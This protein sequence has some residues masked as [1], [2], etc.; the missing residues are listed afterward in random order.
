[1]TRSYL[2]PVLYAA[3]YLAEGKGQDPTVPLRFR[4]W[5]Q[6]CPIL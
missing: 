5:G 3:S 2:F 4:G 1:M 6:A